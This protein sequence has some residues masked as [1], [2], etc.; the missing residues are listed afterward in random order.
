MQRQI[1]SK[2][3]SSAANSLVKNLI[4]KQVRFSSSKY[5]F[6]EYDF[7]PRLGLV[8]EGNPG[9]CIGGEWK[10]SGEVFQSISPSDNRV[11]S[12]SV[13]PTITEYEQAMKLTKKA[14]I[15]WR[16][17]PAPYRGE[18]V[19]QIGVALRENI[20][21]LGKLV[22]L[23]MGKIL[24]EGVGEVQEFVDICDFATGLSRMINGQVMP[25]ERPNHA[26]YELWNPIGTVGAITAFNFPVAVYG[27]NAALALICGNTMVWKGAPTTSLSTIATGKII[28]QVLKDN[29]LDPAICTIMT[30][31]S[32]IGQAISADKRIGLVSFTGSTQIGKKVREVVDDR[33]GKSLLELGG[34]NAIIVCED[35][36]L[37]IAF[38]S[39]LFACVGT[40]GQRCTT[41]RRLIIQE[42][43]YDQFIS[44]L[45]KGY[46][47]VKIGDPIKE[48][49]FLCGPLHTKNAVQQYKKAIEQAKQ[50][51]GKIL[52][53]GNVL[54]RPGN[55]VEP[56]IIEIAYDAPVVQH[57][58]F[59][60]IVYVMKFKTLDEA[61]H[62]NNSVEQGLSSSVF[63]KSQS[64]MFQWLGPNGSDCGIVNVNIPTNGAEIGGAFGGEKATGGGRESGSD[65]WKQYMRRSTATVNYGNT[66]PLAQGIKFD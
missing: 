64:N 47:N 16:N 1:I 65:S 46:S 23:E 61:I 18:I 63:T 42:N 21:D 19:R 15:E 45:K 20:N 9:I 12:T 37:E 51:G 57:E 48:S 39:V 10:G 66:L 3:S 14:E 8:E 52:Y 49:G 22:S 29:K 30:G 56:T 34:N 54:D 55:Y 4:S 59:V 28:Q 58:T 50:Q 6:S 17:K 60:P 7:L 62:I 13:G 25:S 40:A 35:A 33:W 31:G 11:I 43:V 24:P 36:D 32:D 41:T 44:K 2:K 5:S 26:M 27:W 38:R 53:G